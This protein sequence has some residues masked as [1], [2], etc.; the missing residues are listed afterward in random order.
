MTPFFHALQPFIQAIEKAW[1]TPA[2]I[3]R[4]TS[5][6]DEYLYDW[7][8]PTKAEPLTN[9]LPRLHRNRT[10]VLILSDA[11]A[12]TKTYSYERIEGM[13]K[14]FTA[15]SP[16]IRQLIWLN[17]LPQDRWKQTSAWTIDAVLNGK[18]LSYQTPSLLSAAR[19]NP[20]ESMIS[21]W[22]IYQAERI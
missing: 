9:L 20:Q 5:Y 10:I 16:C 15:L 14:F 21:P 7:Y 8:R 22:Q 12:A 1:I 2:R 13:T 6:P 3:Y 4:F 19:E 18:M 17:P 11:G